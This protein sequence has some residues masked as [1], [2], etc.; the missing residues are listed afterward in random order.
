MEICESMLPLHLVLGMN[1]R[2][3]RLTMW[4]N[5]TGM[6]QRRAWRNWWISEIQW[7]QKWKPNPSSHLTIQVTY[8]RNW[9]ALPHCSTYIWLR[10]QAE[11]CGIQWDLE[12]LHRE[13]NGNP[14]QYSCLENPRD[15][16]AWWA[17]SMG[18]HRAGHDW[19]D[20]AAA[21]GLHV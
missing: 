21:E 19:S 2:V 20:L 14:L 16:G 3:S 5:K 6:K 15:R 9:C 18:S 1:M 10:T 8:R 17:V 12:G 4:K 11:K 13:G 7:E